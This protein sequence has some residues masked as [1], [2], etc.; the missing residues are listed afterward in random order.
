[1]YSP[2]LLDHFRHP[3]NVG[4]MRNPDAVGEQE[5]DGCGDLA[6]FYL[7]VVDGRVREVRFQTYGCGATI[8]ASSLG[9]ELASGQPL[10]A[11][12][13]LT[14][15]DVEDA[16]GGLPDDRKHSAEIVVLALQHAARSYL[17]PTRPVGAS[18]V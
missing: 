3:R 4:M 11:L 13:T 5:Y 17:G 16:L 8:A 14:P 9:S 10:E 6:R 1:M 18:N 15:Q 7:R 2:L 12:L